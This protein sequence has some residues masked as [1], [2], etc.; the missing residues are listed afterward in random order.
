MRAGGL[1]GSLYCSAA[2]TGFFDQTSPSSVYLT[3]IYIYIYIC[4]GTTTKKTESK[5]IEHHIIKVYH[6]D[7][8]WVIVFFF[9]FLFF[10]FL[11][12]FFFCCVQQNRIEQNRIKIAN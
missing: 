1:V 4:K 11:F 6:R 9:V 2:R 3:R 5:K 10:C 12:C 8:L 7:P